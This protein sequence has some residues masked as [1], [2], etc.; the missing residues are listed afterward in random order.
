MATESLRDKKIHE[1]KN[2][3]CNILAA[4]EVL[5]IKKEYDEEIGNIIIESSKEV[6]VVIESLR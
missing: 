2:L 5:N 6:I 3:I 4:I 1:A